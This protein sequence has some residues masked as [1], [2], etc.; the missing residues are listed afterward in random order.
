MKYCNPG[1]AGAGLSLRGH[2]Q[3]C[4]HCSMGVSCVRPPKGIST[5]RCAPM[6]I[7][8]SDSPF[9]CRCSDRSSARS[10]FLSGNESLLRVPPSP[11]HN[12]HMRSWLSRWRS[13]PPSLLLHIFRYGVRH[14]KAVAIAHRL[15][16]ETLPA[17]KSLEG[18]HLIHCFLC[19]NMA[20]Q[21]APTGALPCN[22][23]AAGGLPR[24]SSLWAL[25]ILSRHRKPSR[26]VCGRLCSRITTFWG[27]AAH[28]AHLLGITPT[29]APIAYVWRYAVWW[30]SSSTI[31][32]A[33]LIWLP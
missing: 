3:L 5:A 2:G 27:R 1:H 31:P 26:P 11:H 4:R 23:C 19:G 25:R 7:E 24:L 14:R 28:C 8:P 17:P 15:A 32:V 21:F 9:C 29:T 6:V 30:Y 33:R 13:V 22:L 16:T 12:G 10:V 20:L 18:D